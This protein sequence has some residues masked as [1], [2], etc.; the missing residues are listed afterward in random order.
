MAEVVDVPETSDRTLNRMVGA[1]VVVLSVLLTIGN[2]KDGNI[3]QNMQ[4]DQASKIDLWNEYQATKI[5][6][7][8]SEDTATLLS[9][10]NKPQESAAAAGAAARYR[11]ESKDLQD[12]AKAAESDYDVQ[13]RRDDQFDL[14][15]GFMSIALAVSGIAALTESRKLLMIGW[16]A[17][18]FGLLFLVAGF[19][20]LPIHPDVLVRF[21]T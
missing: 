10:T 17:A 21:L 4:G 1:T 8:L 7:H 2:I 9:A 20:E 14:A 16:A 6:A 12:Q 13:G 18:A 3:V 19:L 11:S 5:K 15:E